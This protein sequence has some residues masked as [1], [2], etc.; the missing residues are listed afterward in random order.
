MNEFNLNIYLRN[1]ASFMLSAGIVL[2]NKVISLKKK[3]NNAPVLPQAPLP[4]APFFFLR[5]GE[6]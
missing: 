6:G 1:L 5:G 3:V 2:I 4:Q